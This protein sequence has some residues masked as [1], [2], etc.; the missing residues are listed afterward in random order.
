M[1][2]AGKFSAHFNGSFFIDS[3]ILLVEALPEYMDEDAVFADLRLPYSSFAKDLAPRYR[4]RYLT[5]R[6]DGPSFSSNVTPCEF[7]KRL[8][9]SL[10]AV[11]FG[12]RYSI[13][14]GLVPFLHEVRVYEK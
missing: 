13:T 6:V 11:S 12:L 2:G 1:E 4:F 7:H 14:N 3:N 5:V 9:G 8:I 10:V